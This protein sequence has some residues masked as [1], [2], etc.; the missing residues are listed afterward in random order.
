MEQNI[1]TLI[2]KRFFS[3]NSKLGAA[4][5]KIGIYVLAAIAAIYVA[6]SHVTFLLPYAVTIHTACKIACLCVITGMGGVQS[7]STAKSDLLTPDVKDDIVKEAIS[8]SQSKN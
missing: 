3:K 4:L 8:I 7:V 2:F 1:I 6:S 5:Q